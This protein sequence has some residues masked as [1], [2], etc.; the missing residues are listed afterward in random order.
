MP[1]QSDPAV[2]V[3]PRANGRRALALTADEVRALLAAERVVVVTSLG[4]RG[5]PHAMPMWFVPEG[6]IVSLWTAERSQKVRNLERDRKATL[7]VE[8]GDAYEALRGVMIETDAEIVR[9]QERV[10]A[11]AQTLIARYPELTD[12]PLGNPEALEAQIRRRVVLRFAPTRVAS[13]DHRK[14][15][16]QR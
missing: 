2:G 9:D 6:D 11:F 12:G 1:G 16:A 8:T 13:W 7:L 3:G 15:A 14:M 5:Y 10:R 4:P